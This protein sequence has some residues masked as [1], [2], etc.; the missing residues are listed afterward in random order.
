MSELNYDQSLAL[1]L[2]YEGGYTNHPSDPGGPT[3]WGIT[4]KDAQMYWKKDATAAD[5][6]AMPVSVAK[7]I[8][9]RRYWDAMRCS[10]LPSGVDYAVMDYGVNSGIGRSGKVLRR[11]LGL[12]DKTSVINDQVIA[13]CKASD[14]K[15][16]INFIMSERLAFLKSLKTWPTFGRGWGARVAA[17]KTISLSMVGLP[18]V[19]TPISQTIPEDTAKGQIPVNKGAQGGSVGTVIVAGTTASSTQTSA[20]TI[21]AILIGT[22]IIGVGVFFLFKWKQKRDQEA[23]VKFSLAT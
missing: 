4:I 14:A 18:G 3:N 2:K 22:A 9:R 16:I 17:V 15:K 11:A 21:A 23:P 19:G 20:W 6:K 5:V 10:E 12:S 13:A 1:V 8:Y 7:G